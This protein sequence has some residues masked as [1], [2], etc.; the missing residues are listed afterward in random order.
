MSS[1]FVSPTSGWMKRPSTPSS[2]ALVMYSCARWIG[3]RVWKPTTVFQP[4]SANAARD[5]LGRQDVG[6]ERL[7]VL[8]QVDDPHRPGDAAAPSAQQRGDAGM[9]VVG[10]AV[11]LLGLALD[12]ALEDLLDRQDAQQRGRRAR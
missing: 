12:V 8:G 3:L 11:D 6:L 9:L 10:R 4:R 5:W 7:R 1:D 2:A